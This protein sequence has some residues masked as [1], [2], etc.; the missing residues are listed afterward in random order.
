MKD[1]RINYYHSVKAKYSKDTIALGDF[2]SMRHLSGTIEEL[3]SQEQGSPTYKSIKDGLPIV[4]FNVRTD[5]GK[6]DVDITGYN[7]FLFLDVDKVAPQDLESVKEQILSLFPSVLMCWRS[8][9]G[10]GLG[11]LIHTTG[12]TDQNFSLLREHFAQFE[13]LGYTFDKR[14]FSRTRPTYISLD[15]EAYINWE[16]P[17]LDLSH[18]KKADTAIQSYETPPSSPRQG[19]TENTGMGLDGGL[20]FSSIDEHF[21]GEHQDTPRRRFTEGVR[22]IQVERSYRKVRSGDRN[23]FLFRNLVRIL[24]LNPDLSI[25]QLTSLGNKLNERCEPRMD[26]SEVSS[27]AAKVFTNRYP[28]F[29][30]VTRKVLFNPRIKKG[31]RARQ[32]EARGEMNRIAGEQ[33]SQRIYDYIE[34]YEGDKKLTNKMISEGM[35][36]PLRTVER[37]AKQ[38]REMITNN[39]RERASVEPTPKAYKMPSEPPATTS[40]PV[41]YGWDVRSTETILPVIYRDLQLEQWRRSIGRAA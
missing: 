30:N 40:E 19:S 22:I 37:H 32:G 10:R 34:A 20:R 3:R 27:T 8:C 39:H 18:L 7:P 6:K 14:C 11:I 13:F 38:F 5:G 24:H 33:T 12:I 2:L 31:A 36:I 9:G 35:G 17:V 41:S 16:A 21:T 28:A 25:G 4:L 15:E 26:Q 23:A 29:P 1:A